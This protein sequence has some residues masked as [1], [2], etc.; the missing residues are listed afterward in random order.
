MEGAQ[1]RCSWHSVGEL[2]HASDD[3]VAVGCL[4]IYVSTIIFLRKFA[5]CYGISVDHPL[6]IIP[7]L[8]VLCILRYDFSVVGDTEK[9]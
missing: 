2:L 9:S 8:F 1:D 4:V 3:D 6:Y 5:T 7:Y